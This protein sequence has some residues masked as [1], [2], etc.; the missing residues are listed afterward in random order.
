MDSLSFPDPASGDFATLRA[1]LQASC[2]VGVTLA[3]TR[4]T[5]LDVTK[6][7]WTTTY[8]WTS[9]EFPNPL[10]FECGKAKAL[11]Q[12]ACPLGGI[13]SSVITEST[14]ANVCVWLV[15]YKQKNRRT[16]LPLSLPAIPCINRRTRAENKQLIDLSPLSSFLIQVNRKDKIILVPY[17][18]VQESDQVRKLFIDGHDCTRA[19]VSKTRFSK[20][21]YGAFIRKEESKRSYPLQ[22]FVPERNPAAPISTKSS[23]SEGLT[24]SEGTSLPSYA[25]AVK[26][27]EVPASPL[28][29]SIDSNKEVL[30]GKLSSP[31]SYSRIRQFSILR[32]TFVR[33]NVVL[34]LALKAIGI[35]HDG[36][37]VYPI[38]NNAIYRGHSMLECTLRLK[39]DNLPEGEELFKLYTDYA[40][41]CGMSSSDVVG[42]IMSVRLNC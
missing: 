13:V 35:K 17:T 8:Y 38:S 18:S 2:P 41:S 26:S 40:E 25:A 1:L 20:A 29:E 21:T 27:C 15:V 16:C 30:S 31:V 33:K 5:R 11:F 19:A 9:S 6:Y 36:V 14:P 32:D 28:D 42:Q 10:D 7:V 3:E 37:R 22:A 39:S 24:S 12:A 23:R 34:Y 4:Q